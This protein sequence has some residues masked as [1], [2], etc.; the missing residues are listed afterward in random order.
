[1]HSES[2]S[3]RTAPR[4]EPTPTESDK[5]GPRE[6]IRPEKAQKNPDRYSLKP[7]YKKDESALDIGFFD[8]PLRGRELRNHHRTCQ[9]KR[10]KDWRSRS[11]CCPEGDCPRTI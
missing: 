11:G 9:N 4:R 7:T 6:P 3:E 8:S 10:R 5:G 1:M 2:A